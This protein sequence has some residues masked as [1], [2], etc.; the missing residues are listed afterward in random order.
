MVK[1]LN[2]DCK[3]QMDTATIYAQFF[4][5]FRCLFWYI[6]VFAKC[7][8][9]SDI[10][11]HGELCPHGDRCYGDRCSHVEAIHTVTVNSGL[12]VSILAFRYHAIVHA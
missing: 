1:R 3:G 8:I 12:T 6:T 11:S 7:V 4:L 10:C 2:N 9:N 5:C